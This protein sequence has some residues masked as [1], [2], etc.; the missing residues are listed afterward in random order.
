MQPNWPLLS[1]IRFALAAVVFATHPPVVFEGGPDVGRFVGPVSAVAAFFVLS[2][3]SIGHSLKRGAAGF[4]A[5]RMRRI[6]PEIAVA[7]IVAA[8]AFA[9]AGTVTLP[10]ATEVEIT[11]AEGLAGLWIFARNLIPLW[12]VA[13][14]APSWNPVFWSLGI[15]VVY[16]AVA[17]LLIRLK[18]SM[19]WG[20]VCVSFA[21]NVAVKLGHIEFLDW[22]WWPLWLAWLWLIGFI[23][24]VHP[25]PACTASLAAAPMAWQLLQTGWHGGNATALAVTVALLIGQADVQLP[26]TWRKPALALGDFS[27]TLYALHV[28]VWLLLFVLGV[29]DW[30]V[31]L[32][33][34]VVAIWLL[35]R[36]V[37]EWK[38]RQTRH[39]L[40]RPA[41]L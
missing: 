6:Y 20:L 39:A 29:T 41:A 35:H 4:Y 14:E 34:S 12:C 11:N 40:L 32:P 7:F 16:Y 27:Y 23:H 3:Y 13:W 2:G 30:R 21:L 19:L 17:P 28:P 24:A 9:V 38:A 36:G 5:R 26:A 18:P 25:S 33:L 37:E 1:L 31:A 8:V 10:V 15:E 22:A